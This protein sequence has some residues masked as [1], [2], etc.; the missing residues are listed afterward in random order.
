MD[1]HTRGATIRDLAGAIRSTSTVGS[2]PA[3]SVREQRSA[4]R[5]LRLAICLVLGC[6]SC[7]QAVPGSGDPASGWPASGPIELDTAFMIGGAANDS[8]LLE[9]GPIAASDRML[10]VFDYGS[11]QLRAFDSAG[12]PLWAVGR[13]GRGP[14]E[15]AN[16]MGIAVD[17]EGV[18]WVADHGAGRI[19]TVD[20]EGT[21]ERVLQADASFAFTRV[22]P[23]DDGWIGL[24]ASG[25]PFWAEVDSAEHVRTT[26]GFP[27]DSIV[28]WPPL[29]RQTLLATRAGDARWAVAFPF[30]D[31]FALY[32]G[33]EL[34]CSGKMPG[35]APA[36]SEVP[37][38]NELR[39]HS[40]GIALLPDAI[41]ILRRVEVAEL[42]S[43]MLDVYSPDD[44]RYVR[45][46]RLPER[47]A[48]IAG[49]ESLL[50][51]H[52]DDPVPS[53]I[54]VRILSSLSH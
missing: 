35:A 28:T 25:Q 42:D 2:R 18:I 15:F 31:R 38:P 48:G 46:Y 6:V 13:R 24:T 51:L 45:S 41:L 47:Y 43:R 19:V 20:A 5:A 34:V 16:P 1:H 4:H 10:V 54:A 26:G 11:A 3:R 33:I 49:S 44:C 27:S 17:G 30:G 12:K 22:V 36:P 29:L 39:T 53:I 40:S 23:M 52:D 14:G 9:V 32:R 8:A 21:F 7:E 37:P 50:L